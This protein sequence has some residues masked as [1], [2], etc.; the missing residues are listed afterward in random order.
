M[1]A[2]QRLR[3]KE[4]PMLH[5][6]LAGALGLALAAAVL[7][8]TGGPVW[9]LAMGLVLVLAAVQ[10]RRRVDPAEAAYTRRWLL[11]PTLGGYLGCAVYFVVRSTELAVAAALALTAAVWLALYVRERRTA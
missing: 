5:P 3:L 11:P 10:A 4:S 7:V 9:W 2:T 1:A 6:L 8:L